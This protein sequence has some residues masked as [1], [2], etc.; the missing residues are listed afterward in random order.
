MFPFFSNRGVLG[1]NARTLLYIRP[2]NPKKATALADSK[3]KTKAYLAARGIP[4]AKLYGRIE[5]R[6]Q[7]W[8]FD[9]SQLP[10]ECVL[11]PNHGFGGEGIIVLRGRDKKGRFLR[12]GKTPMEDQ[13]LREHIEDILDGKFSL[14]G[15]MD[16]AFFEQ[17][18]KSH[19]CFAPFRPVGLPDLRIIVFNLVPVMAML[20]IPTADSDGKA[21]IHLGGIGIG[22]DIAKGETTYGVKYHNILEQLPHGGEVSGH[23]IPYWDEI[24]L[25]CSRIQHITNIGYLA[26]D[27]AIDEQ[28]GPAL[29]EVNARAGLNVQIANLAPLRARLDRV[30]GI[31][32]ESPEKGVRIGQDLFGSKTKKKTTEGSQE[33]PTLGLEEPIQIKLGDGSTI[34]VLAAID[35]GEERTTF[36]KELIDDL[37]EKEGVESDET[38]GLY[39]T[40]FTLGGKKI[41]TLVQSGETASH[42]AIVGSRDLNGFL[43]DPTKKTTGKPKKKAV[44]KT[45]SRA[46]DRLLGKLDKELLLLKH[47]KPLN[48]EEEI[49][50]LREDEL[51]NP[52]FT[53]SEIGADLDDAAKR[54]QDKITDDSPLGALLEKKRKELLKRITLLKSRGN[55]KEFTEAS[56]KL[57]GA[58]TKGLLDTAEK[59]YSARI[60]C[61]LTV[62]RLMNAEQAQKRFEEILKKYSLHD[63]NVSI[64]QK[65]VSRVTV[66]G[67]NIY[68]QAEAKFSEED[69]A[70]LIAHEIETHVLT[71]ENG[72]HQPYQ[73]LRRGC[74]GYLDTQEGLAIFN[75]Q[76]VLSPYAEK[77]FNSCRNILGLEYG[78]HHSL[79]QTRTYLQAELGYTPAKAL[80]QS[81]SM[82]R[83]LQ[84]TS[85][86]GGFTKSMAYFRGLKAIEKF[87]ENDGDL[88][89]LYIGKVALEDLELIEKLPDLKAPLILPNFLRD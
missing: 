21:N 32:V 49:E 1:L 5:N 76:G 84:D 30:Q 22:I 27:I 82:K 71:S 80:Q 67:N 85:E 15:M 58:P 74:A 38:S 66:G 46:L 44:K 37:R 73:I 41:K 29:L 75:E 6:D 36:S 35:S 13:E 47:I 79:A 42:K 50:R 39:R 2:F 70:S 17:I 68:I 53:Y 78:L 57:F 16:T 81:I 18:L 55:N 64:R 88:K 51:Y 40:K 3:L 60:A 77:K 23:R 86:P 69:I 19:D 14:K 56:I 62:N 10:D 8:E 4:V 63:W 87:I 12:N 72:S 52:T 9:F 61:D 65:L 25:I 7:V 11:K 43:I 28:M 48:L 89:R 59:D 31:T 26:V 20:R 24:L 54:L 83:G 34:E 33:K 45:D